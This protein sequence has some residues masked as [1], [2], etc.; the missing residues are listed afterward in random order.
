MSLRTESYQFGHRP[1]LTQIRAIAVVLVLLFHAGIIDNGFLGV[2]VFF[3]LSGFLISNILWDALGSGNSTRSV[4]IDF[5][6][7]RAKRLLPLSIAVAAV[8]AIAA[9]LFFKTLIANWT[10]S[11]RASILWSQN[12]F[13]TGEASDYFASEG[14]NPFQHYWSLGVEEQ[15]YV[16]LP[17]VMAL[18]FFVSGALSPRNRLAAFGGLSALGIALSVLINLTSSGSESYL[19]FATHARAYQLLVGCL[20]MVT[21]RIFNI[22]SNS[23]L[24]AAGAIG[25]LVIASTIAGQSL[26]TL[27]LA[28]AGL[29]FALIVGAEMV[30]L[31]VATLTWIG[32]RSYGIYLWHFPI[33]EYLTQE[34]RDFGPWTVFAIVATTSAVLSA[35]SYRLLEEPV[36]RSGFAPLPSLGFTAV[37]VVAALALVGF[38]PNN[39]PEEVFLAEAGVSAAPLPT[40]TVPAQPSSGD[41]NAETPPPTVA[42]TDPPRLRA[43]DVEVIAGWIGLIETSVATCGHWNTNEACVDTEGDP[44]VLLLGDSFG[45]PAYQGLR[46][47]ADENGWQLSAFVRPGCPWMHDTYADVGDINLCKDSKPLFDEIYAYVA[48]DIVVIHSRPYV[49]SQRVRRLSTNEI[50]LRDDIIAI[51]RETIADI[52][53]RGAKVI[54]IEATPFAPDDYSVP[55]CLKTA[56]WA[57]ECDFEFD[58]FDNAMTVAIKADAEID[59][60][61]EFVSINQYLCEGRRCS[62]AIDGISV[63]ADSSHASGGLFVWL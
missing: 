29:T 17:A 52:Q 7:K 62:A 41:D 12:W 60:D 10:T 50:I 8:T 22:G 48:P 42:T 54:F 58:M 59:P 15:F 55:N 31:R 11:A 9:H 56:T 19:Y 43:D 40:T 30:D 63:M 27:G 14:A 34:Y 45:N 57:D 44:R 36:R 5:M 33:N 61:L 26:F 18:F 13:L 51:A 2:D 37:G 49:N 35:V 28:A 3:V 47:L 38:I 39:Q 21:V 32:L 23:H 25:G 4:L 16:A 24:V 46:A 1:L 20:A 53:R 6:T